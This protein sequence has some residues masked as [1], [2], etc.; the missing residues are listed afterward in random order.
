MVKYKRDLI[1]FSAFGI[2]MMEG[3]KLVAMS[4]RTGS[5]ASAGEPSPGASSFDSSELR[6]LMSC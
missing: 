2:V 4:P 6:F 3:R 5:L 1:K